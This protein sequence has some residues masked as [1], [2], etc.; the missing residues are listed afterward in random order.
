MIFVRHIE[1]PLASIQFHIQAKLVFVVVESMNGKFW[2]IFLSLF[3]LQLA[4]NFELQ[5][6][7]QQLTEKDEILL[8][9]KVLFGL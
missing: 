3:I 4:I 1:T 8:I 6:L 5:K 9:H 7:F 2:Y